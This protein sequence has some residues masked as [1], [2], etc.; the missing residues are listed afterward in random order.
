MATTDDRNDPGLSRIGPDGMQET[1]LV[2][3]D[4][5]RAQGFTRPYRDTYVHLSCGT[6]TTMGRPIAETYARDPRFYGGTFCAGCHTHRPVGEDG[7]FVWVEN[8][9]QTDLKVGT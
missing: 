5:E 3:S 7:E 4:A 1:Y 2:L 9:A 6:R 8:G